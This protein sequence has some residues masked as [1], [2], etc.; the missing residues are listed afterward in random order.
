MDTVLNR[1][2][3]AKMIAKHISVSRKASNEK[4]K[5]YC[6]ISMLNKPAVTN[7]MP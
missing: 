2:V 7:D 3:T 1:A 6:V 4:M 5:R